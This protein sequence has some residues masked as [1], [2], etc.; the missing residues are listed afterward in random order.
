MRGEFYY[1]YYIGKHSSTQRN[2]THT[3]SS[4]LVYAST[5]NGSDTSQVELLLLDGWLLV[6]NNII[7]VFGFLISL[8]YPRPLDRVLV[9]LPLSLSNVSIHSQ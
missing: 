7:S 2:S 8:H 6:N 1:Y 9:Y 3:L 5:P 4:P